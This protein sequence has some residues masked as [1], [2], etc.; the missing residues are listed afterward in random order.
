MDKMAE[1]L[2]EFD[3]D[4]LA[5]LSNE[6]RWG[7][8][9]SAL[10][11]VEAIATARIYLP[12][13]HAMQ[14]R[15][16]G[17]LLSFL[18]K[19]ADSTSSEFTD[20]MHRSNA[21]CHPCSFFQKPPAGE[22]ADHAYTSGTVGQTAKLHFSRNLRMQRSSR[23]PAKL[24]CPRSPGMQRSSSSPRPTQNLDGARY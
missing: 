4:E 13:G 10:Q 19:I 6:G 24:H 21:T 9:R 12:E 23:Q 16:Q 5:V 7:S 15:L 22:G 3:S 1:I 2:L 11:D 20:T 8:F 14:L 18:V 17:I